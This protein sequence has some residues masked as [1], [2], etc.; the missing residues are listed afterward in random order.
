MV[1]IGLIVPVYKNFQGFARLMQHVDVPVFPAV[2]PNWENNIGVAPAWNKGL[3]MCIDNSVDVAVIAN[4]DAYPLPMTMTK[5]FN[6]LWHDGY[7]AVS[8]WQ[9]G[10][11]GLA[12]EM[13]HANLDFSFLAVKPVD[14][15]H[16]FGWFDENFKPAYFEDNDM[17]RRLKLQGAK[18]AVRRDCVHMHD[19][20]VTQFWDGSRVVSHEQFRQNELYYAKKWGGRP[21]SERYVRPF[22]RDVEV[23][24][25]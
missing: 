20:S 4:D 22:N 25:W 12:P 3:Q 21:G 15:V 16:K 14:F 23:S 6:S 8:S 19:G 9:N 18:T 2:I 7:D 1:R 17:H 11:P 10:T 24:N 5:L 13:D